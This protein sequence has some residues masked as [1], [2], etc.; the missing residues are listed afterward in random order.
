MEI[1]KH[2]IWKNIKPY[3]KPIH[4]ARF[5]LIKKIASLIPRSRFIGISGSVG[6][7]TTKDVCL[8]VLSEKFKTIAS[9]ENIDPIFNIPDT[10]LKIRPNIEKV[11]LE[12][13]IEYPGEMD[14]YLSLTGPATGIITRISPAH[15]QFLGSVDEITKEKGKLIRQLPK[16]GYAI[17]NWDD[18][19]AR[20]LAKETNAEVIFYGTDPKNCHIWASNIRVEDGRTRFEINYGVER[21]D[22]TFGLLGRHFAYPALAAAALGISC[23]INLISI[24]RGL[25]K[26]KPAP[27]RLQLLEGQN[28]SYIIDDTYNSS[29]VAVE[30]ALNVLNELPARRRMVVLGEMRELGV[31]SEQLHREVARKIYKEKVDFVILGG[32]DARFIGDEL[33][34]LGFLPEKIEVNLSNSQIVPK[35]LRTMGKGDLILVKG[36]RSIKLDEV[37]ARIKK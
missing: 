9:K 18:L 23:G 27:H 8:S 2:P 1:Q 4:F 35:I 21:A 10:I 37:V 13:G 7:T 30:E 12:M 24:K 26:V 29:P 3:K 33:I 16:S 32:G 5:F 17:L 31:Y 15:T 36:S 20:K 28:G 22:V 19:N 11:I 25:E 34:K 14:F 6:K